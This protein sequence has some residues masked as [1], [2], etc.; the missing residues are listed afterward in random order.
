MGI[1]PNDLF[2]GVELGIDFFDC[3]RQQ[4]MA[5]HGTVYTQDGR[6][7]LFNEKILNNKQPLQENCLCYT[8]KN[9]LLLCCT[10]IWG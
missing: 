10:F 7:N 8:C 3:K 2:M 5:R 4:C 9:F 1:E 6:L